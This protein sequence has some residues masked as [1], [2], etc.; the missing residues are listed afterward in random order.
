[1]GEE[2]LRRSKGTVN[3]LAHFIVFM[4]RIKVNAFTIYYYYLQTLL[5]ILML[6]CD[7]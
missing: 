5:F 2:A 1:M 4:L 6:H 7:I 3:K